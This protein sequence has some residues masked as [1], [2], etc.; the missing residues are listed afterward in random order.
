M[1]LMGW[2]KPPQTTIGGGFGPLGSMGVAPGFWFF[3]FNFCLEKN[4]KFN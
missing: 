4:K 2:P 1:G 3:F